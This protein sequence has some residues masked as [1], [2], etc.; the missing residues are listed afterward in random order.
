MLVQ[1]MMHREL[2]P[3]EGQRILGNMSQELVGRAAMFTHAFG[4]LHLEGQTRRENPFPQWFRDAIEKSEFHY[5]D[6]NLV[7]QREFEK[8]HLAVMFMKWFDRVLRPY[9]VRVGGAEFAQRVHIR[10]MDEHEWTSD[11]ESF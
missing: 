11:S 2:S 1:V 4:V 7:Y 9:C 8:E 3:E 5:S 6:V 10:V